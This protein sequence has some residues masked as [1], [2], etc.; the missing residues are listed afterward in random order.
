MDNQA[1]EA[2]MYPRSCRR[3]VPPFICATVD[4]LP[5]QS[6][7]GSVPKGHP[8]IRPLVFSYPDD[9]KV[10]DESFDFMLGPSLLAASVLEPGQLKRPVYLP[11]G[12]RW[13]NFY[14]QE[15]LEGGRTHNV[16]AP[17]DYIPLFLPEGSLLP[18]GNIV[19]SITGQIDDLRRIY[20]CP[21]RGAGESQFDLYEDDGESMQYAVGNFTRIHIVL[22]CTPTYI[23]I[24]MEY[25]PYAFDLP[26]KEIEYVL[27]FGEERPLKVELLKREWIDETGRRH[28]A[29]ACPER[30]R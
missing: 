20:L 15:W 16:D 4:A 9:P 25:K 13:L 10:V 27:P 1:N 30:N 6:I 21:S 8:L 12:Q 29:C 23:E 14:T 7:G 19:H 11:K 28:I 2:W 17:L 3:S 22:R 5:L 26:Y 18:M 24:A